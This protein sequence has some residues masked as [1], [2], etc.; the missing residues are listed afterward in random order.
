MPTQ[1]Q[2]V[3]L[4]LMTL[5]EE[6][7]NRIGE[8]KAPSPAEVGVEGKVEGGTLGGK[9][10]AE[11]EA[12]GDRTLPHLT[13]AAVTSLLKLRQISTSPMLLCNQELDPMSIVSTSTVENASVGKGKSISTVVVAAAV[14]VAAKE[15]VVISE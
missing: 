9:V 8:R 4:S 3:I 10:K 13:A 15:T 6:E 1:H 7:W 5:L 2:R 12:V 11:D 14:A